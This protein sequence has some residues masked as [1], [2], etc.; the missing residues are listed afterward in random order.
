[1]FLCGQAGVIWTFRQSQEAVRRSEEIRLARELYA[2]FYRDDS[3]YQRIANT[4]EACKPLYISNGGVFD[5]NQINKYLG[6]FSDLGM[7]AQRD[8]LT[9]QSIGYF[10]GP[11]IVE[12][13]TY[14][15]LRKYIADMRINAAQPEAFI[16]LDYI[17]NT[18]LAD[19][20]FIR[21]RESAATTC[22]RNP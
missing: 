19:P 9:A 20:R 21:L 11:F 1:M 4:I 13:Y 18:M 7:M 2:E 12:A 14:Y 15:E 5:Y 8:I 22:K 6:F 16:E 17:A 3:V 10:F